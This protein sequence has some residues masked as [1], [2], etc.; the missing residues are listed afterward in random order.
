LDEAND[1]L[2]ATPAISDTHHQPSVSPTPHESDAA[3]TA[4]IDTHSATTLWHNAQGLSWTDCFSSDS[5]SSSLYNL[6]SGINSSPDPVNTQIELP[7]PAHFDDIRVSPNIFFPLSTFHSGQPILPSIGVAATLLMLGHTQYPDE[8]DSVGSPPPSTPSLSASPTPTSDIAAQD[9]DEVSDFEEFE[10][11]TDYTVV[12]PGSGLDMAL[13]DI[14]EEDESEES[15]HGDFDDTESMHDYWNQEQHSAIASRNA[16]VTHV[17]ENA[18]PPSL[19]RR[20]VPTGIV[21]DDMQSFPSIREEDEESAGT[22]IAEFFS[23]NSLPTASSDQFDYAQVRSSCSPS[24]L[25][26]MLTLRVVEQ[27][28]L[29]TESSANSD[30][31]DD[32]GSRLPP[33]PIVSVV[34]TFYKLQ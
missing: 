8:H 26:Y 21:W 5:S 29:P 16:F 28:C 22:G 19:W 18:T 15:F 33:R 6:A 20:T 24:H 32:Y 4:D 1:E 10:E 17:I 31:S 23:R 11:S 13:F 2:L 14:P 9:P 34:C 27:Y 30:S 7:L 12:G 25:T 3:R